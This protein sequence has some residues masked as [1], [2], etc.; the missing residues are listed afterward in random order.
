MHRKGPFAYPQKHHPKSGS[1]PQPRYKRT[2][3]EI[4]SDVIERND[5]SMIFDALYSLIF[6]KATSMLKPYFHVP[7]IGLKL[8]LVCAALYA[9]LGRINSRMGLTRLRGEGESRLVIL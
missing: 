1:C 3:C 9:K 7:Q 4:K 6:E 8:C 5:R 2:S